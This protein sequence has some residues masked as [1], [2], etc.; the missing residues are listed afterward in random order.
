MG[1]ALQM[2]ADRV[3]RFQADRAVQLMSIWR[4]A[5]AVIDEVDIVLH[6]LKSE[7][8]W[9]LGDRYPLDFAPSRLEEGSP[10]AQ[11]MLIVH[12]CAVHP[13][14]RSCCSPAKVRTLASSY[15]HSYR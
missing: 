15:W 4:G 6:P 8:N 1:D 11:W 14:P 2:H 9:P 7:L 5:V 10:A 3:L 12:C 13:A